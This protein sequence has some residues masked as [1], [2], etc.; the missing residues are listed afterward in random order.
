MGKRPDRESLL[1]STALGRAVLLSDQKRSSS[2][3]AA[4]LGA[5]LL[6]ILVAL[7]VNPGFWGT[8]FTFGLLAFPVGSLHSL[9][10]GLRRVGYLVAIG[11]GFA[12]VVGGALVSAGLETVGAILLIASFLS[13]FVLLW[14]VR[15]A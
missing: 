2:A 4:C 8:A 14:V 11:I 3:F 13:A 5:C 10:P 7:V 12:A 9:R 1:R 6:T 15:L